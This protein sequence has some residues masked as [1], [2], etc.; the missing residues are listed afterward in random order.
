MKRIY[1]YDRRGEICWS[2]N[3]CD[4]PLDRETVEKEARRLYGERVCPDRLSN[5]KQLLRAKILACEGS[6][7]P[8]AVLLLRDQS[9]VRFTVT[10]D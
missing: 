3:L 9:A 6:L 4:L 5:V 8:E 2:G 1:L 7:T 10:E